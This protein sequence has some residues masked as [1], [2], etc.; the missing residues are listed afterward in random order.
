MP[1]NSLLNVKSSDL[2]TIPPKNKNALDAKVKTGDKSLKIP[3]VFLATAQNG[4][5]A[6][7]VKL[8]VDLSA[9]MPP[10]KPINAPPNCNPHST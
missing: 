1:T 2:P 4:K 9:I 6:A 7:N 5:I 3:N 10:T 8:R